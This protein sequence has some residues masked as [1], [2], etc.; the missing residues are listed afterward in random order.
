LAKGAASDAMKT[1][2]SGVI[3]A[4]YTVDM[5][6]LCHSMPESDRTSTLQQGLLS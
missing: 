6:G 2:R 1:T 5:S 3:L 4:P